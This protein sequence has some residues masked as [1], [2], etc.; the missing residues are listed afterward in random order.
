VPSD[1]VICEADELD[2]VVTDRAVEP[3]P[4]AELQRLGV[5]VSAV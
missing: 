5:L 3:A 4:L 2:W 1:A